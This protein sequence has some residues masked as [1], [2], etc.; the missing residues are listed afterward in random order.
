MT[1][2]AASL[3]SPTIHGTFLCGTSRSDCINDDVFTLTGG[4]TIVLRANQV[5][6]LQSGKSQAMTISPETTLAV[7][8]KEDGDGGSNSGALS[9][10]TSDAMFT[11]G[12]MAG[13]GA[14]VGVLLLLLYSVV[15][16][17]FKYSLSK[18]FY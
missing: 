7:T 9:A 14:G 12:Q 4:N 3:S 13:L 16:S 2:R 5:A 15:V 18:A 8:I 6:N 1:P 17:L 11:A 10:G